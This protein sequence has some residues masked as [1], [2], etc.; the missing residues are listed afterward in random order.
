MDYSTNNLITV[1]ELKKLITAF[2]DDHQIYFGCEGL[3]FYRLKPRGEKIVQL[4]FN[5]TVY[6]DEHGV[7]RIDEN[8]KRA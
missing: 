7:L 3:A 1:G 8:T 2:P 5:Q 6:R 4:E